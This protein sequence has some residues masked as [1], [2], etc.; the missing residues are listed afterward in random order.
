MKKTLIGVLLV[1]SCSACVA[2]N[3]VRVTEY[4]MQGQYSPIADA[5]VGG[6]AMEVQGTLP[7][8]SYIKYQSEKCT[9]EYGISNEQIK[10]MPN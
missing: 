2:D 5:T 3:Y 9:L 8:N 4:G 10:E 6:C 7:D 1:L